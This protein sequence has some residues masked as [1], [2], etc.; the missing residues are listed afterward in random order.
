MLAMLSISARPTE[1]KF[2]TFQKLFTCN[3]FKFVE[4]NQLVNL[5][6]MQIRN[7]NDK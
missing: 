1:N 4:K 3:L 5:T 2:V 7:R 6:F